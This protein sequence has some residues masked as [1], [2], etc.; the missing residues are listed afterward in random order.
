MAQKH[1][2]GSISRRERARRAKAKARERC[3]QARQRWKRQQAGL[4]DKRPL[5]TPQARGYLVSQFWEE[6]GLAAFLSGLGI[7]KFKGLAAST[8]LFIALLFGVMDAHSISN[9]AEKVRAD[10]VLIELCAGDVVERKQLY[11]FLGKLTKEQYQA[12]MAHVLRQLQAHLRTA[13][14]PDGVMA[15]DETTV[16]KWAKKMPGISWVFKASEQRVGL[17]YEIVSTCYADGDKFYPLFCDF[18]LPTP[19]EQ[20]KREQ[21]RKRKELG[22]DQRKIADVA[23]W[24]E[25]QVA[26]GESPELVV[27][28]GNHLGHPLVSKC[29][30]LALAWIG[31]S[32][33]RRVYVLGAGRRARKVKGGTL[34][35]DDY[36]RQWHELKDE[37]YQ[38]SF[39]G[40]AT[41][42]TLG[43]VLLLV[44]ECLA[45]GERQLLVVRP[46]QEAVLLERVQLLLARQARPDN[47]KLHLMLDLLR[48][49]RETGIRAQTATFDRWF[50]V[51]W[52]IQKVLALGFKR[53][54]I[55]AKANTRYLHQGQE[56]TIEEL[57]EQL[58]GYRRAAGGQK[59][60][61][62][63][64]L[65]V[66]QPGLGRVRLVFVQ[67]LNGRGK[68]TQ[69]YVL[70]CTDPRYANDKVWRAHKLRWRIEEIYREVR[71]NHGFEEFHCRN[72]NAIYGH[73][74]LSFLSYLC[75]TVTRLMAPKLRSLTL[76]QIKH[77]VFNALVELVSTADK[78]TV[79][80]TDEFLEH[81]GLPAFCT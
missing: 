40:E 18:R 31:I 64:S 24:L 22:L 80:F 3:R 54:V 73:V 45:D 59:G 32:T 26:D 66:I 50:Y 38:V 65:K 20:K 71:Q 56:M 5:P 72:F 11:R 47:T 60:V 9:L 17:G 69:E 78:M 74:A 67:E 79:C 51:L 37:G 2:T 29:E 58:K 42:T 14:R 10:P 76:G 25:H 1:G 41:A 30:A 62:F 23:C 52:F 33:R 8:L 39:L 27:L 68:L 61:K 75:L 44:I 16:L 34:L 12:L 49:G 48:G 35:K 28:A 15:G 7:R 57:K 81:Y 53:V 36:R 43:R 21:A 55:K 46:E 13:S 77:K 19:E 63:A 70:M 6:F 4:T